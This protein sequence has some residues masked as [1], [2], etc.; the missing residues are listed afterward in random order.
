SG[1]YIEVNKKT[2]EA[3]YISWGDTY[4]RKKILKVGDSI[5]KCFDF[6]G[7]G[8]LKTRYNKYVAKIY[9]NQKGEIISSGGYN[10]S[11]GTVYQYDEKGNIEKIFEDE[12]TF[13]IDNLINLLESEYVE[14]AKT[15]TI[16]KIN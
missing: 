2:D 11:I 8:N 15:I 4:G 14:S 10:F 7:T 6:Y 5:I 3:T 13:T 9:K 12:F 16:R 1:S